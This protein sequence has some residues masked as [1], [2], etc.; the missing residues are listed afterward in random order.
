MKRLTKDE[1]DT[2]KGYCLKAM[3]F[4]LAV[5]VRELERKTYKMPKLSSKYTPKPPVG[6]FIDIENFKL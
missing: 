2:L 4:E 6:I 1:F 3:N 5:G